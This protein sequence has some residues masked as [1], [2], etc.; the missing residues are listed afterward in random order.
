MNCTLC[1]QPIENF[2][3]LMHQL[4]IKEGETVELCAECIGKIMK[5]QQGIYATLFPTKLAK[6]LV[7]KNF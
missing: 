7:K 3:P 5:W 1:H 2:N 4:S 6:K